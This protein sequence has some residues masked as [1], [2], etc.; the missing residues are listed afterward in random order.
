M[1]TEGGDEGLDQVNVQSVHWPW[2]VKNFEL[3]LFHS[4]KHMAVLS[5]MHGSI[6]K[7]LLWND[8]FLKKSS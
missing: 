3:A 4:I 5:E 6:I 1:G 7:F 2:G 8:P